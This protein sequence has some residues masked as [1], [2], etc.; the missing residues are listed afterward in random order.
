M[1]V[2]KAVSGGRPVSTELPRGLLEDVSGEARG[3]PAGVGGVA[4]TTLH[5]IQNKIQSLKPTVGSSTVVTVFSLSKF[6]C[7]WG[8]ARMKGQPTHLPT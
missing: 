7:L 4:H 3:A 2:G 6:C 1:N 8:P 5:C